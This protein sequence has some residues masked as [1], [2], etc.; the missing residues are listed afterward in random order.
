MDEGT[1]NAYKQQQHPPSQ[2]K[3]KKPQAPRENS[4]KLKVAK[5]PI[6]EFNNQVY[7]HDTKSVTQKPVEKQKEDWHSIK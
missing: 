4:P 6:D 3:K 2:N 5:T 1:I 7:S